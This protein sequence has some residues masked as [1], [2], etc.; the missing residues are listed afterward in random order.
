MGG[1][2]FDLFYKNIDDRRQDTLSISRFSENRIQG[3]ISSTTNKLLF[4]S[5]PY[6]KGWHAIIDG[7]PVQ[8]MLCNLGFMG[9]FIDPGKHQV[10]LFYRPPFF[11]LS[12]MLSIGGILLYL[13][14]IGTHSFLRKK[15]QV[16]K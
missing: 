8:P 12:L 7:K 15:K 11:T 6:D 10:E 16:E 9:F 5:I 13:G 1:Y 14:L 4:F 2:T 3:T